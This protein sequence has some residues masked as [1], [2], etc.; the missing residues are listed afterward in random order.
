MNKPHRLPQES[1]KQLVKSPRWHRTL[2]KV[3]GFRVGKA[4]KKC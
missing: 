1:Q 2:P 3:K 4:E